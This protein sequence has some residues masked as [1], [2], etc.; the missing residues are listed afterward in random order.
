MKLFIFLI[1]LFPTTIF[2]QEGYESENG[3]NSIFL[4]KIGYGLNSNCGY[5]PIIGSSI[6]YGSNKWG[7]FGVEL[8]Y[9]INPKKYTFVRIFI[10]E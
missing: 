8:M 6:S 3:M 1:F 7:N 10:L 2:S 9:L 5:S 4:Q